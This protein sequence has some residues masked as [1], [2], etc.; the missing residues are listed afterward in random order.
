MRKDLFLL[1]RDQE[2]QTTNFLPNKKEIQFTS[3]KFIKEI[4]DAGESNPYELIAQAK[5]MQEAIDVVTFELLSI[6]PQ[7]NFESFGLKGTFRNGGDTVNF[8]DDEIWSDI[9]R[10]LKE[11]EELIK[12][13]LKS[14]KEIY[15][16]NGVQ[17]PK[18]STTPRKSS[19]SISF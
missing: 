3:K 1:M 11:R 2:V 14:D 5:R 16:E 6:L 12:V 13:A 4:L 7:E 17:V 8:K 18:V 9:Q 19:L 10:E 15:D